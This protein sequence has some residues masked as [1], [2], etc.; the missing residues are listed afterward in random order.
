MQDSVSTVYPILILEKHNEK[1]LS[2]ALFL[3]S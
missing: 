1:Q 3:H 2:L